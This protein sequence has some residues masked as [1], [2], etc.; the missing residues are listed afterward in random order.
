[1]ASTKFPF[2]LIFVSLCHLPQPWPYS[3]L[4]IPCLELVQTLIVF[5]N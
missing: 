5:Y 1:M 4:R 3:F 2:D